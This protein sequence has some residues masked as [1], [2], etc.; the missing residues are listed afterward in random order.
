MVLIQ[1]LMSAALTVLTPFLPLYLVELGITDPAKLDLWSGAI[2]SVNFLV[3]AAASPFWGA[4]GDRLGR[5]AMVLRSSLAIC[6]FTALMGLSTS[7]WQLLGLRALMGAF[8]GFSATAIALVATQVPEER[9]GYALGWLSTGQLV[10]GLLGPIAGGALADL[11]RQYRF[12]FFWTSLLAAAAVF[13]VW[14]L[15]R[16]QAGPAAKRSGQSG[17][18]PRGFA[19]AGILPLFL[20]LLLVQFATRAVQPVVTLFVRD[21]THASGNIATLAG[22][23]FSITGLADLV[24]SPFLGKRSDVLGYRRVLLV[25]LAGAAL[26]T[27]PQSFVQSY[28]QFLLARFST[29]VF[30]GGLLPTANALIGRMVPAANRGRAYG[31]TASATFLGSFLGPFAGGSVAAAF[32]IRFVFGLTASLLLANFAWVFFRVP[33]SATPDGGSQGQD[34]KKGRDCLDSRANGAITVPPACPPPP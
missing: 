3:A 20:V 12:V 4:L 5:R 2:T 18:S 26:C 23:A 10:G 11:L 34:R 8:S 14:A 6:V 28:W 29:G 25:S 17:T 30:V 21:L 13:L 15:V 19:I 7:P 16:E 31:V 33:E 22:A 1:G 9:L 32:G 24:A 27:I